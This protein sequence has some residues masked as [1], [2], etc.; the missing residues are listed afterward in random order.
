MFVLE[1]RNAINTARVRIFTPARELPFAGHPTVGTAALLAHLRARDLLAA[2]DLRDR[3]GGRDRRR[4][5]RRASSAGPGARRLF[6]AAPACPQRLDASR[7]QTAKS[8][9]ASASSPEDI[10]FDRHEPS[11]FSGGSAL[12]V[13]SCALARRDRPRAA[14]DMP[15]DARRR[16]GGLPLHAA[17]SSLAGSDYHA[18]MFGGGWG[19]TEDPATGSAAAAFAGVVIAFDRAG[20][21]RT[22]ARRSSRASRWAARA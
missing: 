13:R 9:L 6:R 1:P 20:R 12:S 7:R 17:R 4:R 5:L 8:P 19:V 16:T 21:R 10:G 18:R 15:W 11:L 2:Q 22:Y 3:V 14:G